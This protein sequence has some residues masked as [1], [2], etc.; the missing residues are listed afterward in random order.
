MKN[1]EKIPRIESRVKMNK[2]PLKESFDK[3]ALFSNRKDT[4]L[5]TATAITPTPNRGSYKGVKDKRITMRLPSG[6]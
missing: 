5:S 3:L 4:Y 1:A 6:D 2:T